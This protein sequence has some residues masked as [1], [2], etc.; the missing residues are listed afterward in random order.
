[1]G[2]TSGNSSLLIL[3]DAWDAAAIHL[4]IMKVMAWCRQGLRMHRRVGLTKKVNEGVGNCVN[5]VLSPSPTREGV[6]FL[7]SPGYL[8]ARFSL[9][10]SPLSTLSTLSTNYSIFAAPA[11][12]LKFA[13]TLIKPNRLPFLGSY[14][15]STGTQ[16]SFITLILIVPLKKSRLRSSPAYS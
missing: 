3:I 12:A 7:V 13:L 11:S 16:I 6:P 10:L 5:A 8:M 9:P 4:P 15:N 2:L 1:M 14:L